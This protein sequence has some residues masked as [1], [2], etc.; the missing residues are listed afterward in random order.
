MSDFLESVTGRD[1]MRRGFWFFASLFVF[2]FA[3]NFFALIPGVG[4]FGFGHGEGWD[5]KVNQPLLRG[6]NANDNLTAAYTAV[7]F[8][9]W[10]YW[11]FRQLGFKGV[12]NDIFGSKVKFPNPI[13]NWTFILIF[14]LVGVIEVFSIIVVRPIAFTFRLYGN[15][16]GGESFLDTIYRTAPNHFWATVFMVP[17]YL[18][19]FVVAFV[20]AFVFFILTA[21]FTGILT[22]STAHASSDNHDGKD[23]HSTILASTGIRECQTSTYIKHLERNN[24]LDIFAQ[25][26]TTLSGNM[27]AIEV[28]LAAG[29]A[30]I[31]IGAVGAGAS[32]A[33]G[34]NPGAIGIILAVSFAIIA[35]SE[36]T[37]ILVAFVLKG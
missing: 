10:F 8:F 13:L 2:I 36:G 14:F 12:I 4:T 31:G 22:N 29:G 26:A 34:R 7:F 35:V 6:A 28:G 18:W 37:F 27:G 30:A 21:V 3:A 25:T 15:I 11:V 17:A 19:E 1:T 32:Q 16:Y 33:V 20:Q 24:M 5:F 23:A 9:M